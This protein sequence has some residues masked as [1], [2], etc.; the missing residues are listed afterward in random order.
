MCE[1]KNEAILGRKSRRRIQV[2]GGKAFGE[3]TQKGTF[4]LA[5]I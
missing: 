3:T 4:V 5:K 2:K 1:F